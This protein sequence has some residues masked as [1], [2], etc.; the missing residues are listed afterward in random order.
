MSPKKLQSVLC[1]LSLVVLVVTGC[2]TGSNSEVIVEP[3]TVYEPK[4][5][6]EW[7]HSIRRC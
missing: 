6:L 7:V 3:L 1:T 4:Q 5:E 2:S